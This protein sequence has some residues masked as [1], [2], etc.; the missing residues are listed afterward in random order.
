MKLEQAA[1]CPVCKTEAQIIEELVRNPDYATGQIFLMTCSN[2]R[3][4]KWFYCK[5][6]QKSRK[7]AQLKTH[8]KDRT[9]KRRCLQAAPTTPTTASTTNLSSP[10][11]NV[12]PVQAWAN[13]L[14]EE[15]EQIQMNNLMENTDELMDLNPGDLGDIE[16]FDTACDI[17]STFHD[18]KSRFDHDG[19][20]DDG[21]GINGSTTNTGA[22]AN[23][24]KMELGKG[25]HWLLEHLQSVPTVSVECMHQAFGKSP[26]L[27]RMKNFW[28]AEC[29]QP[30]G[31]LMYL[32]AK[33]FQQAKDSQLDGN[34]IPDYEEARWQMDLLTQYNTTNRRQRGRQSQLLQS[35][36]Q[37]LP[38]NH[39]FFKHTFVPPLSQMN[40]Y[41]GSGKFSMLTNFENACPKNQL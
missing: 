31:G 36:M 16:P 4:Q 11:A 27:E 40:K 19:D 7:R 8:H 34:R 18:I 32:A 35:V 28:V 24:P 17:K 25:N 29:A 37:T 15:E 39:P 3:N 9:L 14:T 6:C 12:S 21:H 38:Q 20:G 26:E 22:T 1:K 2:C 30:G 41:Y 33:A 10:T 5:C 23:L 13:G